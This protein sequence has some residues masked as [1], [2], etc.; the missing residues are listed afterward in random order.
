MGDLSG[1]FDLGWKSLRLS[2]QLHPGLV[3][4]KSFQKSTNLTRRYQ[5]YVSDLFYFL[6]LLS[7]SRIFDLIS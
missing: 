1:P 6:F 5:L 3:V 2:N 7:L 4:L